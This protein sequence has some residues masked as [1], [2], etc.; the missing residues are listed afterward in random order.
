MKLAH[1]I[2]YRYVGMSALVLLISIPVFYFILQRVMWN[3]FDEELKFE[4]KW[5]KETLKKTSPENFVSY[6]NNI[7]IRPGKSGQIKDDFFTEN[8]YVSDD[9][10]TVPYRVLEFSTI[11]NGKEYSIRIQ[12]SLVETDDILQAIATLQLGVLL[13]LLIALFFINKTLNRKI[14][15]PFYKTLA[16]LKKY[17]LDSNT[18]IHFSQSSITEINDLNQ[19]IHELTTHNLEIFHAQKEFTENAS[20]ELQTPLAVIQSNIDLLWQTQPLTEVQSQLI[21]NLSEANIRMSRLNKSL[22]LLAKID[23]QQFSDKKEIELA[24]I[25]NQFIKRNQEIYFY[26]K[27]KVSIQKE[28][29]VKI[30]A[31][32]TLIEIL[33][34]NLISNSFRYTPENGTIFIEVTK[35][36]FIIQN[37]AVN[38]NRLDFNKLFKRFQKQNNENADSL[39]LGLEICKKIC[40]QNHFSIQYSFVAQKH[41][42]EIHFR[43]T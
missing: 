38:A 33:L 19:S 14:W 1:H 2:S 28:E 15:N 40:I 21:N 22:L 39:G 12:K 35:E 4:K 16:S 23:N 13:V 42:F 17:K 37:D 36:K 8:I 31:D 10:E 27:I 41:Q 18:P 26:K 29:E 24:S 5:I 30:Y 32:L 20:H 3:N 11:E 9:Q 43:S 7:I 34:G 6:N 25:I